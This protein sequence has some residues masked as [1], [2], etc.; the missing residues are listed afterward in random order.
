MP[1]ISLTSD[2]EASCGDKAVSGRRENELEAA[3]HPD[4]PIFS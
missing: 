1:A 4:A 2:L 3:D